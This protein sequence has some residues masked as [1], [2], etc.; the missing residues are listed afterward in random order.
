MTFT[1]RAASAKV[2]RRPPTRRA[3]KAQG[4]FSVLRDLKARGSGASPIKGLNKYIL[5]TLTR[6]QRRQGLLVS[7][8]VARMAFVEQTLLLPALVP[9]GTSPAAPAG[10]SMDLLTDS[11]LP[12]S[13]I[14]AAAFFTDAPREVYSTDGS[15]ILIYRT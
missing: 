1:H 9:R 3:T 6:R 7:C 10:S 14:R 13:A 2:S 5:V 8:F 11:R 12:I 4:M 15:R